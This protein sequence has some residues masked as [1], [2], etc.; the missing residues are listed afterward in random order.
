MRTGKSLANVSVSIPLV[1]H[2]LTRGTH[3][4]SCRN[5]GIARMGS[6]DLEHG[7]LGRWNED[8]S[9][10]KPALAAGPNAEKEVVAA[11]ARIGRRDGS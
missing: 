7:H 5:V 4:A 11:S 6:A 1:G 8:S 3:E 10:D 2:H 9:R